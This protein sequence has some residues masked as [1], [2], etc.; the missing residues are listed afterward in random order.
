ME[1]VKYSYF[2]DKL[3]QV[4]G[5]MKAELVGTYLSEVLAKMVRQRK[6]IVKLNQRLHKAQ[7]ENQKNGS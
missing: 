5:E 4:K 2:D 6:T 3:G 7:L 1:W